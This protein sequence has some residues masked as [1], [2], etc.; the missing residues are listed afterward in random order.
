MRSFINSSSLSNE[1]DDDEEEDIHWS[2]SDEKSESDIGILD[3]V[4]SLGWWSTSVT[5]IKIDQIW[6][7]SAKCEL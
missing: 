3:E 5:M 2:L 4:L 1:A 6:L 7:T